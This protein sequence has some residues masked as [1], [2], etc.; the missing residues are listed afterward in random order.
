MR[1]GMTSFAIIVKITCEWV[2]R[3]RSYRLIVIVDEIECEVD[4]LSR[5]SK[6]GTSGTFKLRDG[7]LLR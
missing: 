7:E 1:M 6:S 2:D 3:V 5:K 4:A